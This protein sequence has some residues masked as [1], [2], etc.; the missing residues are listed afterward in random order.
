[1]KKYIRICFVSCCALLLASCGSFGEALLTGLSSMGSYTEYSGI[2]RYGNMGVYVPAT[3]YS[4]SSGN[5][6]STSS[7]SGNAT[8]SSSR[9]CRKS[10]AT[11]LAHCN[12]NGKCSKCNGAGK[13]YDTSYGVPKWVDPCVICRGSGKCPSCNGTGRR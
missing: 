10:S 1:M 13:Y 9:V 3:A 12:G 6:S 5:V 11:D 7:Q 4:E 8:S 2:G